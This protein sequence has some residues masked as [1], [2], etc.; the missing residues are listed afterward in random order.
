MDD[1]YI[2]N[3]SIDEDSGVE[4]TIILEQSYRGLMILFTDKYNK[5]DIKDGDNYEKR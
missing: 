4:I 5:V 2:V 1:E 3:F